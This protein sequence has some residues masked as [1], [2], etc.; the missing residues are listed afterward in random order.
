MIAATAIAGILAIQASPVYVGN[1]LASHQGDACSVAAR[2][3]G[4]PTK[5][6]L[7]TVSDE[8]PEDVVVAI[9]SPAWSIVDGGQYS[10]SFWIDD[11][12]ANGTG[13]GGR[14][15]GTGYIM[16]SFDLRVL[17]LLAAGKRLVVHA[18]D[19]EVARLSL[20]G[21]AG[22]IR[23]MQQ[24]IDR[25]PS[26]QKRNS[27]EAAANER[28]ARDPFSEIQPQTTNKDTVEPAWVTSG[29]Y[30]ASALNNR[31]SGTVAYSFDITKEGWVT[32]CRIRRSS[33]SAALDRATCSAITRRGHYPPDFLRPTTRTVEAEFRWELPTK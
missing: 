6:L 14:V 25:L 3:E 21:S 7:F 30:P 28:R 31:E 9:A 1:W 22:A 20:A 26:T 17:R 24:C 4:E 23:S 29:D 32:N 33:G 10:T 27:D 8:R 18:N 5:T 13:R 16:A 11:V 19:K 15:D 2:Y 12:R